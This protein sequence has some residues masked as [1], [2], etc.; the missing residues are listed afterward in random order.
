[1]S[2]LTNVFNILGLNQE[3]VDKLKKLLGIES[4]I[5]RDIRVY[6]DE[7]CFEVERSPNNLFFYLPLTVATASTE[8]IEK[9]Y[10]LWKLQRDQ[11]IVV[12]DISL[13]EDKL[14]W[15]LFRL[16]ELKQRRDQI[17]EQITALN[18]E[19]V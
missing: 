8:S 18:I 7:V 15:S 6:G 12:S 11:K 3:T 2:N 1:M 14:K 9:S 13:L 4:N 10:N 16:D 19:S 17:A 5:I